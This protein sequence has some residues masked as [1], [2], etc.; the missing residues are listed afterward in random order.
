MVGQAGPGFEILL[1]Q[2]LGWLG[3]EA[4]AASL[5]RELPCLHR[6]YQ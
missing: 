5:S 4:H 2:L 3:L 6:G 1:P